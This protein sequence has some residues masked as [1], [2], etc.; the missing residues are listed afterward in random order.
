[1]DAVFVAPGNAGTAAEPKVTNVQVGAEDVPALVDFARQNEVGLTIVGP[2]APLV[3]GITDA[4]RDA[5]L[6][7]FGPSRAAAE[8]EG[9]KA[10][11]KAFLARHGIPTADYQSF[12]DL[13]EAQHYIRERGAPI[14]IKADGLAAGKG[15]TVAAT[16]D[17]AL[18]AAEDILSGDAFGGAGD[19]IVVEDCLQGEE[20]SFIALVDGED[21]LSLASSQD[22]KARDDG[23]KGPNT[24]GMGA[25][26]PA[27]VVTEVVHRRIMDDVM[28]PTVKGLNAEGRR[29]TGFLYAGLMIDEAG[30]PRVLEFNCRLGDPEAQPLLMR[31]RS[32]LV[33]LCEAAVDGELPGLEA[34]WDPRACLG[35]VMAA[36][37]YPGPYGKGHPIHGLDQTPP[38]GVKVFHAGTAE[39]EHGQP[40]TNGGRVLS[41][42]ALGET[43]AQAQ[44]RAYEWVGHI[45]W[46]GAFYR[47]DIGHRAVGREQR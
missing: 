36:S 39:D 46:D 5:G 25:Y 44:D 37:G 13:E 28:R 30:V 19:R 29:Y 34:D 10:F 9:S 1:V 41:V 23:D 26:S 27:P 16:I 24:G 47:R 32:D 11:A 18:T 22:H 7:C 40:V 20:A 42:C 17:D 3:I 43:V 33:S 35:V 45:H 38:E 15:V 21:V 8:L 2:E 12:S 6:K 4:F 14:V 31:L